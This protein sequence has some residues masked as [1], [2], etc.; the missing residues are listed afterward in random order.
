MVLDADPNI[1]FT[2][3]GWRFT[4]V[5]RIGLSLWAGLRPQERVAVLTHE[6]GHGKNSDAVH[7]WVV[8]SAVSALDEIQQTFGEQPLDELRRD[9]H[10]LYAGDMS[11]SGLNKLLDLTIGAAARR[12]QWL[13]TAVDLR[14]GQRA[15]YLADRRAAEIG[16]SDATASALERLVLAETSYRALHQALRFG[17]EVEPLEAVTRAV[18]EVPAREIER[19]VRVSRLR[20]TRI[21]STHPPTNLRTKLIRARPAHHAL[22]VLGTDENRAIDRELAG[23]AEAVLKE[24]RSALR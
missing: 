22:V 12:M 21:D 11:N 23:P 4:P 9:V 18:R 2:R 8:S 17:S 13:L 6:L 16:G 10:S 24:L 20:D 19:R 7:G 15:E 14:A 3:V 1:G 5:I